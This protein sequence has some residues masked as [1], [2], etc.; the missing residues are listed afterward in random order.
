MAAEPQEFT[1]RRALLLGAGSGM[2]GHTARRLARLGAAVWLASRH[3]ERAEALAGQIREEGG[4]AWGLALDVRDEAAVAALF[5][6]PPWGE[7]G[8]DLLYVGAGGYFRAPTD[9]AAVDGVWF[10]EALDN[11]TAGAQFAVRHGAATVALRQG[12]VVVVGA[13]PATRQASNPAYAAGKAAVDGLVQYWARRLADAGVR[14]NAVLPG[15]IRRHD[16][17]LEP[18]A[19]P[20]RLGHPADVAEAVLFFVRSPWVTGVLLPV[21]GG[22]HV[23]VPL[24]GPAEAKPST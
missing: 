8:L 1:G 11:L 21:D 5:A 9:P 14:V 17:G 23:G 24:A 6:R 20:R 7:G 13:S 10:R 15:L 12:V 16:P 4:Q 2:G 18:P 22:W 3:P 19:A